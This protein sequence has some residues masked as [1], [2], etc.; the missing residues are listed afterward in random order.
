MVNGTPVHGCMK[1]NCHSSL[2]IYRAHE[3][4]MVHPTVQLKQDAEHCLFVF[5]TKGADVSTQ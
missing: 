3:A 5:H 4:N 1:V 2:T